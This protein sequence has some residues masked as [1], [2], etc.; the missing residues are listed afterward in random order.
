MN[1]RMKRASQWIATG[2]LVATLAGSAETKKIQGSIPV[3]QNQKEP[4]YTLTKISLLKAVEI[5][6]AEAR[7]I[8]VEAELEIWKGFLVYE[9]ELSTGKGRT[10]EILIDAG[11]G[12]VL[13]QEEEE[14]EHANN[15]PVPISLQDALKTA[16]TEKPGI[17]T[18]AELKKQ[19][20]R[21]FYH[22]EIITDKNQIFEI[23]IN[24]ETGTILKIKAD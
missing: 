7:G 5:A 21:L 19:N 14:D 24:A 9:V 4:W 12:L 23:D 18:E 17:A 22:I 2:I 1:T 6:A 10:I 13:G 15:R 16:R 8:P 11:T 20:G 3:Q